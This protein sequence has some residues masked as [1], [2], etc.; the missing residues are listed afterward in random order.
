MRLAVSLDERRLQP[1]APVSIAAA[2]LVLG[3]GAPHH[4]VLVDAGEAGGGR[5]VRSVQHLNGTARTWRCLRSHGRETA[6]GSSQSFGVARV[7]HRRWFGWRPGRR[8]V[9]NLDRTAWSRRWLGGHGREATAGR[10]QSFGI[11]PIAHAPRLVGRKHHDIARTPVIGA[12]VI[13]APGLRGIV[14]ARAAIARRD[15]GRQAVILDFDLRR[16]HRRVDPGR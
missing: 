12:P 13:R 14:G 3:D 15:L 6:A 4:C 8:R 9:Q 2:H 5:L 16:L 1:G 10:G 11:G 7:A